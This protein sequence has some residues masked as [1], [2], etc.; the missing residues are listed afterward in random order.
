MKKL[1]H[2]SLLACFALI[3][4]LIAQT[5]INQT[6]LPVSHRMAMGHDNEVYGN[7]Q[8]FVLEDGSSGIYGALYKND[9]IALTQIT[10]P[11]S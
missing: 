3:N 2:I 6:T 8:Y 11:G 1:L 5:G 10:M 4:N 7:E 9:G